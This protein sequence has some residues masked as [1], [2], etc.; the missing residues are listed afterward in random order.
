MIKEEDLPK[1]ESISKVRQF[2]WDCKRSDIINYKYIQRFLKSKV[3]CKWD[4]VYSEVCKKF[5][6][7]EI[8]CIK[9]MVELHVR[10]EKNKIIDSEGKELFKYGSYKSYY[11]HP[12]TKTLCEAP[13]RKYITRTREITK[14]LSNDPLHQY[15]LIEGLWYLIKLEPLPDTVKLNVEDVIL[16]KHI[17]RNALKRLYGSQVYGVSKKQLNKRELKDIYDKRNNK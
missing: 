7:W 12:D 5:N 6:R 15:H 9:R 4:D 17:N 10:K 14:I 2:G 16:G 13:S 1:R 3:D 11:I 8:D